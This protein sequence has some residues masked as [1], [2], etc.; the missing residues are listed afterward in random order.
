M[1]KQMLVVVVLIS[2]AALLALLH[3]SSMAAPRIAGS[4]PSAPLQS[5]PTTAQV[6]PSTA[7]NDLD[8]P[9]LVTGTNFISTPIVY[10]GTAPL[11]GVNWLSATLLEAVAP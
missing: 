10:V 7:P 4:A 9:I 6:S 3:L 2:T 8:A 11:D 1:K 5:A